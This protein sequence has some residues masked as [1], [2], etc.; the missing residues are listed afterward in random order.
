MQCNAT[1]LAYAMLQAK[2]F[3]EDEAGFFITRGKQWMTYRKVNNY[4]INPRR[5]R[6]I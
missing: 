2:F 1:A 6:H 5:R 3:K 4:R